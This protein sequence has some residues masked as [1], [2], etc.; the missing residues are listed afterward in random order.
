MTTSSHLYLFYRPDQLF[1]VRRLNVLNEIHVN[2]KFNQNYF[3][4]LTACLS[5]LFGA[6]WR[7]R[8]NSL[9]AT[10]RH[11]IGVLACDTEK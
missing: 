9:G 4:K 6:S 7:V 11:P 5:K 2:V 8:S 1:I 10:V 3:D